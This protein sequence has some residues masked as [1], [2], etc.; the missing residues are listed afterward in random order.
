MGVLKGD[1]EVLFHSFPRNKSYCENE[2]A[3]MIDV[4]KNDGEHGY[5]N[6]CL[7]G[8]EILIKN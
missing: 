3:L 7:S 2:E 4:R 5:T 1:E 6:R 8:S